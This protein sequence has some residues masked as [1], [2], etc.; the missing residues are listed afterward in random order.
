VWAKAR[1]SEMIALLNS[2]RHDWRESAL[3]VHENNIGEGRGA[4]SGPWIS[5]TTTHTPRRSAEGGLGKYQDKECKN[6]SK[7][8]DGNRQ[9]QEEGSKG[10]GGYLHDISV[11]ESEVD[12]ICE[13]VCEGKKEMCARIM[14]SA[15]ED[16]NEYSLDFEDAPFKSGGG[17]D[18][19]RS[20]T[21]SKMEGMRNSVRARTLCSTRYSRN[22]DENSDGGSY[23]CDNSRK[24]DASVGDVSVEKRVVTSS[25]SSSSSLSNGGN[26]ASSNV[27]SSN[28]SQQ[29]H[30]NNNEKRRN[31]HDD[32]HSSSSSSS[33]SPNNDMNDNC[34]AVHHNDD[35]N[36]KKMYYNSKNGDMNSS[37]G[38]RN[39]TE[40][41]G[42]N[43]YGD[44][45]KNQ[46]HREHGRN[47][48]SSSNHNNVSNNGNNKNNNSSSSNNNNSISY[49][50]NNNYSNVNDSNFD[51][52]RSKE[53]PLNM[54]P[55]S[56]SLFD[57]TSP[58]LNSQVRTVY[59]SM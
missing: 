19:E 58:L 34:T 37:S 38:N 53:H 29:D 13:S 56:P 47:I 31:D 22:S 23:S 25:E 12:G 11:Q 51:R 4:G 43:R 57:M 15:D 8:S 39:L 36:T 54:K 21:Q 45:N 59:C 30:K 52:D 46:N 44:D 32:K 42:H 6:I 35:N 14:P 40:N 18:S 49:S 41:G 50:N 27:M 17:T 1:L 55:S 33:S 9:E 16:D 28:S 26:T 2:S 48:D 5:D 7:Y 3:K 24:D 20:M 10:S